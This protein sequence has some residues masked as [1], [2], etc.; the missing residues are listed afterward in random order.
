MLKSAFRDVDIPPIF[1]VQVSPG[2]FSAFVAEGASY[3]LYCGTY[4]VLIQQA[5][6]ALGGGV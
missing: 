2:N 4:A 1:V 3:A 5:D 6:I